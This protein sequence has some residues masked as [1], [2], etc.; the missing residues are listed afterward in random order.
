MKLFGF[1]IKRSE[2]DLTYALTNIV[3]TNKTLKQIL[4]NSNSTNKKVDDFIQDMPEKFTEKWNNLAE[5]RRNQIIA[6]S[7]FHPLN[8]QYQINN[9]WQTRDLREYSPVMEKVAMIKEEVETKTTSLPYDMTSITEAIN[10]K[11]KK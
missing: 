5:G 4:D 11:F 10:A 2:D 6:E 8:T 9:F 1:Q 7:K 3:K